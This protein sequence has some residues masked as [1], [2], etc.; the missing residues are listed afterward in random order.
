MFSVIIFG[1]LIFI[2]EDI[3]RYG[4]FSY[5]STLMREMRWDYADYVGREWVP[6]TPKENATKN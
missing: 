2:F 1:L 4:D 6:T 5:S 3:L